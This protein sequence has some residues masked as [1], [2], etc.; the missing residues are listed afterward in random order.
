[1]CLVTSLITLLFTLSCATIKT[2]WQYC[3]SA[4]DNFY[5]SE[6]SATMP[7]VS[8]LP[9]ILP[10]LFQD[11]RYSSRSL[12][13]RILKIVKS[14]YLYAIFW[15]NISAMT[16]TIRQTLNENKMRTCC[17]EYQK[18][19]LYALLRRFSGGLSIKPFATYQINFKRFPVARESKKRQ[20]RPTVKRAEPLLRAI[21]NQTNGIRILA[22][23]SWTLP[24]ETSTHACQW[25]EP[26]RIMYISF[27][28]LSVS[29]WL[30]CRNCLRPY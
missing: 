26:M 3:K 16:K 6:N 15:R 13:Y 4:S 24:D 17:A 28:A 8:S 9:S 14:V 20:A 19:A 30:P 29:P 25:L 1:M 23:I 2:G 22:C 11:R 12:Y 7:F 27:H 18:N 10:T 5:L 21:H